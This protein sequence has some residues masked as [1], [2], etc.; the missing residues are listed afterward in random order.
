ML[1]LVNQA[2]DNALAFGIADEILDEFDPEHNK[3]WRVRTHFTSGK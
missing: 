3:L 1:G 2:I